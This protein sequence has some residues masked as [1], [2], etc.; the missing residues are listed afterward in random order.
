MDFFQELMPHKH[1]FL[2]NN[3][4][5]VPYIIFHALIAFSSLAIPIRLVPIVLAIKNPA[6]KSYM[7]I[8]AP[9]VFFCGLSH[10]CMIVALYT[11]KHY[12]IIISILGITTVV[13]LFAL[14][15][16]NQNY[17]FFKELAKSGYVEL[18]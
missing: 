5:L 12:L 18:N 7:K 14:F 10:V 4:I 15:I 11:G 6:L 8:S 3:V 13:S 16:L 9:Y 2:G 1:C 17:K